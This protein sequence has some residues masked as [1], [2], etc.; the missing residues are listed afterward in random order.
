MRRLQAEVRDLLGRERVVSRSAHP[1]LGAAVDRLVRDGELVAVLPGVYAAAAAAAHR[2]TTR[3]LAL[4]AR[5]PDAVLVGRSAAQ[6]SFWPGLAGDEVMSAMRRK[7]RS[8]PG[9]VMSRWAVPPE[10]VEERGPLRL[11]TPALTALDLCAEVA[12]AGIDQALRTRAA[13]LAEMHAALDL[14]PGRPGNTERRA[15]LLDSRD[16]PWS[17]AERLCHRLLRESGLAGWRSNWPAVVEGNRC[18]LDVAFPE[19]RVCVEVDGR[20]HQTDAELF[21]SDR[22]RQNA[23]VLDGWVVLRVTWRMLVE[24]PEAV[25]AAIREAV[26]QRSC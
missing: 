2:R 16:E 22:W 12:G 4:A 26:A 20:L 19:L 24:R 7:T 23:L 8:Q 6:L 18:Y 11:T 10:L 1:E 3:V 21:E 9:F 5:H 25:V 15:L 17:E 14:T 13:T